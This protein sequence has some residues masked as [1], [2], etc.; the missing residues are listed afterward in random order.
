MQWPMNEPFK[1]PPFTHTRWLSRMR[2]SL[3]GAAVIIV[4]SLGFGVFGY[5]LI[6]GLSW[7]DALLEASMILSGM[8]PVA[9]LTSDAVKIFASV[10]ALFSGLILISTTGLLLAPWLQRLFYHTHR[11]AQRDHIRE[12]GKEVTD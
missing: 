5:H 3:L 10:Y 7:V 1:A 11:Q 2:C 9:P 6:G 4:F 12:S 8:G